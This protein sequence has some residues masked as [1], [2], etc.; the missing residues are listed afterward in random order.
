MAIQNVKIRP[1]YVYIGKD[2]AQVQLITV[3]PGAGL[4][5]KYFLFHDSAGAKHYAW[6]NT[7]ASVDPAPAG[8]WTGHAVV[9]TAGDT[10]T[11]VAVALS[12]V[13][14]AVAG[15]DSTS[16]IAVVTLTHTVIGYAMPARNPDEDSVDSAGFAYLVSVLGQTK[17]SAGCI[18]GDIEV[19][20]F[21]QDVEEIKCHASGST[22]KGEIIKG[23]SKPEMKFTLQETDNDSLKKALVLAGMPVYLPIGADQVPVF[24]YGPAN[25]GGSNPQVQIELHPVEKDA[26][27]KSED[28]TFW[29]CQA[30]LD[31]LNWSGENRSLIPVSFSIYPDDLKPKG[32]QY[33][34][35]G[36]AVLAGY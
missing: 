1:Q 17:T 18:D 23:Y 2:T 33:F 8:G 22:V 35:R 20:G 14:G 27:D 34:M 28:T 7:G 32:I 24:G 16:S 12:A 19:S 31:T 29:K 21:A 25:V 3:V 6:F 9:I 5:G 26:A 10:A 4:S 11:E 30:S 13:L 36:D 15:F